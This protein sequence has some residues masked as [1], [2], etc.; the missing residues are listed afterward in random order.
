ME[1]EKY[2]QSFTI[3]MLFVCVIF[4]TVGFAAYSTNLTIGGSATVKNASWNVKFDTNSYNETEGSVSPATQ[5]DLTISGTSIQYAVNLEKPGDFYEF[6]VDVV[7]NGTFDAK[8]TSVTMSSLSEA[9]KKYL[10]YEITYDGVT[11]SQTATNLSSLLTKNGGTKTA[12][13]T[14]TYKANTLETELPVN[15]DNVTLTATLHYDQV[16]N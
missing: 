8:L 14:V 7:N 3:L 10:T 13:V 2:Q 5:D 6:E 9:Q 11:Y 16:T 4:M 15:E 12:K 1:R